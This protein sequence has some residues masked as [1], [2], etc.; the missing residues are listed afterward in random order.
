MGFQ[1]EVNLQQAPAVEGDFASA[2]PRSTVLAG[3][4]A[5]VAG[6]AG[7]IVGRF[8]WVDDD[9]ITVHSYG[10]ADRAPDGFVHREQ[11]ALITEYLQEASM[12]VPEGFM[13]TLTN[14]GDF[15]AKVTG[16][17]AATR[18]AP[19]YAN[20]ST[21]EI[22]IGSAATGA[23]ATGSIGSTN[24]GSLGSTNTAALGATFTATGT[25]TS[26]VVTSVTGFISIGD[27]ISGDGVTPGTTI[28]AQVSGTTGGAGTYTTSAGT[29]SAADTITC[30]GNVV[31]VSATTG[32]IT[33]GDTL[34]GAAGYPVGA[35][36]DTQV[37][38]TPGGA[39]TYALSAPGTAYTA[40]ATG[41]TTFGSTMRTTVTTGLIAVGDTVEGGAGFPVGATVLAQ[42][43]G[44]AGGA[45]VYT[46]SAPG[47]AYVASATGVT[48]YGNV[49]NVTAVA[50][51]TVAPGQPITGTGVPSGAVL[52][53]QLSGTSGGV[54]VYTIDERATA[55]AASTALTTTGGVLTAWTA[56]TA[57]AVD[58]L[59]K[60]STY[61]N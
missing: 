1:T 43:S 36:V 20:F 7:V 61:G 50:S 10:T 3:E 19:V 33:I 9:G 41:V 40:S 34:N 58:E 12:T 29:T 39:G 46:L 56:Q 32:L 5:F 4:G 44:T 28:I 55:Y 45:G 22:T 48:T 23:S 15:Y 52:E 14:E 30:F 53:L 6:I 13:V 21:G 60:I 26:F 38:G 24:T 2:N 49:V 35:T 17:T 16:A 54:G 27:V 47:S 59:T 51:G 8:A 11:Q 31:V 57:A 37:S 42:V 25:G 18:H